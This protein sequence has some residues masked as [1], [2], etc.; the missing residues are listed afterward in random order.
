MDSVEVGC[1]CPRCGRLHHRL[2]VPPSAL[3]K[4]EFQRL[5][6]AFNE[7]ANLAKRQDHKINEWLKT[8]IAQTDT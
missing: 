4:L 3:T 8:Q 6:R 2:G 1:D 5:S 7:T